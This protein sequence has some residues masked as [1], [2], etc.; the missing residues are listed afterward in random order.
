MSRLAELKSRFSAVEGVQFV[1]ASALGH[2]NDGSRGCVVVENGFGRAVVALNGA[3]VMSWVPAGGRDVLW[4]S[5]LSQT[6][7]GRPIRGGIPLCAPWFGPGAEGTPLHG[8]ARISD[9]SVEAIERGADG[10]TRLVLV[11]PAAPDAD[12]VPDFDL[13]LVVE[14]GASLR[15]DFTAVNRADA[16]RRFELAFHTYFA[17]DDVDAVAV[18]GL[19]GC[20]FVDRQN[21]GEGVQAGPVRIEHPIN[22]LYLDPAAEQVVATP[23]GGCRIASDTRAAVVWNPGEGAA[24]VADLGAGSH[25][26][27]VCVE[28]VDAV[29]RAVTLA[30]GEAFRRSM[31]LTAL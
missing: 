19:E 30:P 25:R 7:D 13:R 6:I 15:L 12:P 3:H 9:W 17:V 31:A 28:R 23:T 4:M 11:L 21:P 2:T 10:V 16:A 27:F 1:E 20:A 5:P 24:G 8:W 14:L 26:G 22:R 29:D 18:S